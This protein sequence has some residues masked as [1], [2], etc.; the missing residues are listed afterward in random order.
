MDL[1]HCMREMTLRGRRKEYAD[2]GSL[3]VALLVLAETQT[4][5]SL[6]EALEKAR[7]SLKGDRCVHGDVHYHLQKRH[8]CL[9]LRGVAPVA[10]ALEIAQKGQLALALEQPGACPLVDAL[11]RKHPEHAGLSQEKADGLRKIM[12]A[13]PARTTWTGFA[14]QDSMAQALALASSSGMAALA[15]GLEL[16]EKG[17]LA[18]IKLLRHSPLGAQL[19]VLMVSAPV[20]SHGVKAWREG[21]QEACLEGFSGSRACVSGALARFRDGWSFQGKIRRE[22]LRDHALLDIKNPGFVE[23]SGKNIEVVGRFP[24]GISLFQTERARDVFVKAV[25]GALQADSSLSGLVKEFLDGMEKEKPAL[26]HALAS[27]SPS[28]LTASALIPH[29]D[30]NVGEQALLRGRKGQEK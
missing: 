23:M 1:G 20:R 25:D 16:A 10:L 15:V 14:L 19:G 4:G 22:V 7:I 26:E 28:S 3:D 11:D 13:W 21:V 9:P 27:G 5:E 2:G 8:L 17:R 30:G 18:G 24:S 12:G 29:H 6:L